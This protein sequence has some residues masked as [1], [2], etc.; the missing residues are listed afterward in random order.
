MVGLG[1]THEEVLDALRD[2]HAVGCRMLTIGQYLAPTKQHVPVARFVP[3]EEFEQ[4][5]R[6]ALAMGF[7]SVA[8]GPLVR[9]SYQ[10]GEQAI[11]Q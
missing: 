6:E 4:F 3:P 7:V 2:L 8:S 5:R 11:S 1:E 10:A 9:S